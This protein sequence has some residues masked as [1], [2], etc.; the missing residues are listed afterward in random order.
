MST[1]TPENPEHEDSDEA[2]RRVFLESEPTLRAFMRRRLAQEADVEDCLQTVFIKSVQQG[3]KVPLV[4]RRAWLFRVA[5]NECARHWRDRSTT[6]RVLEKQATYESWNHN[7]DHL[8]RLVT[9]ETAEQIQ[10]SI[11]NLPENWQS[12]LQLRINENLTFQQI[13]DQLQ[14]PLGTALTQM[15]RALQRLRE[16][17]QQRESEASEM[18]RGKEQ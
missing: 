16:D 17:V 14:I 12:I 1:K 15:R 9:A 11:K 4:A 8:Q 5:A 10:Q 18:E 6:N 13:A 3:D 7:D 2:W